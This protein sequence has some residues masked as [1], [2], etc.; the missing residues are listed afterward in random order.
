MTSTHLS[1]TTPT[2]STL[3]RAVVIGAG[4][5]AVASLAM[6]MYA[7][8][9]AWSKDTG[10]FTPLYHI[11]S[12]FISQD[13]MMASMKGAMAGSA[14]HVELGPA[15]LG[16][17]I[18]MMTGAMY[19]AMFAVVVARL[20]LGRSAIVG[21]G[22]LYGAMVFAVS[23]WIGLP[24]AASVFGS[25]D[26]ITHMARMAGWGTFVIEHLVFGLALGMLLALR[27][28]PATGDRR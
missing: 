6:A 7:M 27:L 11:A 25:G 19:G 2:R 3:F 9:A 12:L 4:A 5:G 8:L 26:Q 28:V 21:L 20:A 16:A 10:F 14:F 13:A 24:I 15:V 1:H 23:S 18:H 17:M 22:L